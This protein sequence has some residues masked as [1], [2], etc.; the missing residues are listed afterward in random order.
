MMYVAVITNEGDIDQVFGPYESKD[1]AIA[2]AAE[3]IEYVGTDIYG[4][5]VQEVTS[6]AKALAEEKEWMENNA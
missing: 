5:N 6:Q 4:Y 3:F 1:E 2:S